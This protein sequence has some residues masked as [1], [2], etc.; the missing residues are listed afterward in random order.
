MDFDFARLAAPFRMQPGL[1]RMPDD[2][3]NLSALDPADRLFAEKL[4]ALGH[5][6]Q[7][8]LLALGF[9]G[10]PAARAFAARLAQDAPQHARLDGDRLHLARLD[11]ALDLS[12]GALALGPRAPA[13][14]AAALA[15]FDADPMR[16]R[17]A[18]FALA[19]RED[20]AVLD[21][22]TTQ[23]QVLS[24]CVPSHWA[25]EDK[26]G[27]PF[28]AAHM[29]VAD[30]ALL[31]KASESL[32]R[33]VTGSER[34]QRNVW[35]FQPSPHFDG[36]PR[37][38]APRVW[39]LEADLSSLGDR[40]WARVEHQSFIPVPPADQGAAPAQAVFCIRLMIEP[41]AQAIATPQAAAATHAAVASMSAQVLA[42][43]SL[44]AIQPRLLAWLA[45]R[46]GP[47]D[48]PPAPAGIR[49]VRPGSPAA[50]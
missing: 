31:I 36:H 35:T 23:L 14:V 26:I 48:Q 11:A 30:N 9:D 24:V 7:T 38:A 47:A 28:A 29:P 43:R 19:V 2:A 18:L 5:P 13:G 12:S 1:S 3:P 32:A 44:T 21:G 42:Y 45:E 17:W 10:T 6:E 15:R 27:L 46:A 4:A 50:N 34:W 20:L 39:P 25:P 22:S 37:R 41:M 8:V 16:R 33:L 49:P 40:L